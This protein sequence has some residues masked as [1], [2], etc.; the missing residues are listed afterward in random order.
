MA[1]ELLGY[2]LSPLDA[3]WGRV[4]IILKEHIN[5]TPPPSKLP[6]I[7]SGA[8]WE[9]LTRQKPVFARIMP[10]LYLWLFLPI[11]LA[12]A[13]RPRKL[14]APALLVALP[15][16]SYLVLHVFAISRLDPLTSVQR[17]LP[18][19]LALMLPLSILSITWAAAH[20]LL[21]TAAPTAA[22]AGRRRSGWI[23]AGVG[24]LLLSHSA[25][26]H[27]SS[28]SQHPIARLD[29][30]NRMFDKAYQEGIPIV[31]LSNARYGLHGAL[32]LFWDDFASPDHHVPKP[33]SGRFPRGNKK[34]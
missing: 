7:R 14:P 33:G 10:G 16:L 34:R 11:G 23:G 6:Q 13:L 17:A 12:S 18:R 28:L 5:G 26:S 19:Y 3:P 21:P 29:R 2:R 4:S 22:P 25:L 30:Y 31:A 20:W 1:I 8:V 24:L 9:L 15:A 27:F 32:C